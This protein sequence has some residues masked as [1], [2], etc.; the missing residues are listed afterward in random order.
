MSKSFEAGPDEC[1]TGTALTKAIDAV[2]AEDDQIKRLQTALC[3]CV[4]AM[5]DV[6]DHWGDPGSYTHNRLLTP[7]LVHEDTIRELTHG[8]LRLIDK[9][10]A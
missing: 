10:H 3:A 4:E 9:S 1:D 8:P 6:Q 2:L 5:R 7:M